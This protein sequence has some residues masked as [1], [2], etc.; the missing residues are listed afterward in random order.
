MG[1]GWGWK[2]LIFKGSHWELGQFA[3]L[4]GGLGTKRRGG[5]FE[6]GLI[7]QCTLCLRERK[8]I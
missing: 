4:G 2:I 5:A 6:G 7:R 8:M 3:G 1:W